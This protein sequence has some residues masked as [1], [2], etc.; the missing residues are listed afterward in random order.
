MHWGWRRTSTTRWRS[1]GVRIGWMAGSDLYLDPAAS[2]KVT[3]QLA[4]GQRLAVSEQTLRLHLRQRNLLASVD[5]GRQ[6]LLIRRTL[7]GR[8]RQVLH[9]RTGDL[10]M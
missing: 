4:E 9:L 2:Y 7:E 1:Q 8:T 6:M 5:V 3:Q 10:W